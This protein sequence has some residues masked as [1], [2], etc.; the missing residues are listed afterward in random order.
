[1]GLGLYIVKNLVELQGGEI[2][3]KSQIGKGTTIVFTVPV[4]VGG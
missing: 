2:R 3:A 4:A 1:M